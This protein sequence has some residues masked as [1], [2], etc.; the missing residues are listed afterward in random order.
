MVL[1]ALVLILSN[2]HMIRPVLIQGGPALLCLAFT[3]IGA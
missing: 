2:R 3:L 1:A